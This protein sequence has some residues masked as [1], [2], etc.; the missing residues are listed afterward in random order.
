MNDLQ[1]QIEELTKRVEA[2][3]NNYVIPTEE[4]QED[5]E[6]DQLLYEDAKVFVIEEQKVSTSFL[7]RKFRIGYARAARLMDQLE[8]RGVVS[9]VEGTK[10][11]EVLVKEE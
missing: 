1:K 10:A 2:L 6:S 5:S 3:E 9:E 11:R 7:Q 8:E 4:S